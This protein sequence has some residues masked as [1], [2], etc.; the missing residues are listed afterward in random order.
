MYSPRGGEFLD[1][2]FGSSELG[3]VFPPPDQSFLDYFEQ[4][5]FGFDESDNPDCGVSRLSTNRDLTN[6]FEQSVCHDSTLH[7]HDQPWEEAAS[8][9]MFGM[10]CHPISGFVRNHSASLCPAC[11]QIKNPLYK[12]VGAR[13]PICNACNQHWRRSSRYHCMHACERCFLMA[14]FG[15]DPAFRGLPKKHDKRKNK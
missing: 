13:I 6:D 5:V 8:R 7:R 10:Y 9:Y 1:I 2:P 4:D 12:Y 11:H 3:L 14:S 15:A